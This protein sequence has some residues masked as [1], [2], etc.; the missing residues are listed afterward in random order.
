MT[1]F[2]DNQI[3][4]LLKSIVFRSHKKYLEE[5]TNLLNNKRMI[6]LSWHH[7][8]WKLSFIRDFLLKTKLD[9]KVFFFHKSFLVSEVTNWKILIN[10]L[11]Q[12]LKYNNNIKL[13]ILSDFNKI[14]EIKDF[15][16]YIYNHK[17][18]FKVILIWNTIQIPWIPELEY[19][20]EL[21]TH[22]KNTETVSHWVLPE[23]IHS[24][25]NNLVRN[26]LDL[27][28]SD[29]YTKDIFITFSIKD[30]EMYQLT[31]TY[32]AKLYNHISLREL[33]KW[34]SEIQHITLK[35]TIDYINFSLRSKIIKPVH[36][37]DFKKEKIISSRIKY[38]FT[39]NGI[40]NSISKYSL[41]N[42]QLKENLL[43]QLLTYN[44]YKV[45]S[46]LNG[47]FDFTFYWK[48]EED[49][50]CLHYSQVT[51]KIELKKEINK[52]NKVPVD[53][54]KYLV[55]D[56]IEDVW[57]KKLIYDDVEIVEY[58]EIFQKFQTK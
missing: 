10:Q 1:I 34:L 53:W 33:Q 52:L 4:K 11:N 38:Y 58:Q 21:N 45:Y 25:N 27:I 14:P 46:G 19:L 23:I 41:S 29:M 39:D 22:F 6:I 32:L 3:S 13:I 44:W 12:S 5:L 36:K 8:S 31:M 17:N 50:L 49:G 57:I 51:E 35:T 48:T 24:S 9:N 7:K 43:Y 37:Y 30:I 15:I 47:T 56:S 20:P 18:N 16:Q 40:R 54:K 42:N 55:L 26:Y 28:V 2:Q